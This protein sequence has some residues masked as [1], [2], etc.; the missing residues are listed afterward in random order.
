MLPAAGGP[1]W[2]NS[3]PRASA[4]APA[5][6]HAMIGFMAKLL[7][8]SLDWNWEGRSAAA[9]ARALPP[10]L[11]LTWDRRASAQSFGYLRAARAP[12]IFLRRKA[13]ARAG[14]VNPPAEVIVR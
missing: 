14:R 1:R 9:N 5:A 3:V 12:S 11:A 8:S 4:S 6:Q 7:W 13:Q 10:F 2:A